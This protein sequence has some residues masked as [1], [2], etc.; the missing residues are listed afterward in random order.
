MEE[1]VDGAVVGDRCFVML[2][3]P[4]LESI[5]DVRQRLRFGIYRARRCASV[6]AFFSSAVMLAFLSPGSR[7]LSRSK[8]SHG[9]RASRLVPRSSSR[10]FRRASLRRS[11]SF[12]SPVAYVASMRSSRRERQPLDAAI[13]AHDVHQ[14]V[15]RQLLVHVVAKRRLARGRVECQM[16]VAAV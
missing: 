10:N 6:T 13:V 11:S 12:P 15:A 7:V 8:A 1:V 16:V 14:P 9:S 3:V 4:D 2:E 5:A